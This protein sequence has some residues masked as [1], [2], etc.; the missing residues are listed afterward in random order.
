MAFYNFNFCRVNTVIDFVV[1]IILVL[2]L[3]YFINI[4][5][6]NKNL[7]STIIILAIL[8][9]IYS[10]FRKQLHTSLG[11]STDIDMLGNPRPKYCE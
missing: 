1:Y 5:P 8:Y 10:F 2:I 7:Y 6:F 11:F 4:K 9:V 3:I